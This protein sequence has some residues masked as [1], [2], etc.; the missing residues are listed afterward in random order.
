M[1]TYRIEAR[2]GGSHKDAWE[3]QSTGLSAI[4]AG[5]EVEKAFTLAFGTASEVVK[6]NENTE[7][8]VG[9]YKKIYDSRRKLFRVT[10]VSTY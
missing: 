7:K 6:V 8:V 9:R 10:R 5:C 3:V 1:A 2:R 4:A